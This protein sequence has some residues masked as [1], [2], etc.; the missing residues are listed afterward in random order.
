MMGIKKLQELFQQ[1]GDLPVPSRETNI[2]SIGGRGYYEEPT[3]DLLAFFL[4]PSAEH[5]L[6]D[7]LLACLAE[8][9]GEAPFPLELEERPIREYATR[10]QNRIDILLQGTGWM[11]AIENK[12]R[13]GPLN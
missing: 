13:S 1:I 9:L 6:G 2:F 8:L 4:D 10:D 3:S 7:L 12:I 11:M 5:G